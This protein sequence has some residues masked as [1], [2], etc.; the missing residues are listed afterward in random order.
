[1]KQLLDSTTATVNNTPTTGTILALKNQ[2]YIHLSYP[3][4]QEIKTISSE[5]TIESCCI[6]MTPTTIYCAI[7]YSNKDLC[8]YNLTEKMMKYKTERKVT[9]LSFHVS[10][11][12]SLFTAAQGD[13]TAYKLT[14]SKKR[15][16]LG[17]T[18]S[19]LLDMKIHQNLIFTADRDEKIRVSSF[20]NTW[21]I[22]GYLLGHTGFVSS[23]EVGEVCVSCGGDGTVRVWDYTSFKLLD[24][25]EGEG[26]F[27]CLSMF[28]KYVA[29]IRQDASMN[30][31]IELFTIESNTLKHIRTISNETYP[32]S[33]KF[34]PDASLLILC[35]EPDYIQ[36]YQY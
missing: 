21:C 28:G 7:A 36:H 19:I 33:L 25:F 5:E 16:L 18:A 30:P 14:Q 31:T 34:L 22:E 27:L 4:K 32:L 9:S 26:V 12:L 23:V 11:E 24:T 13:V 17:H 20:P 8:I 35:K 2:A 3:N 10:D 15:V 29:A 6:H 1:M